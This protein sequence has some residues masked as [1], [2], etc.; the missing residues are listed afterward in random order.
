MINQPRKPLIIN[1]L[2]GWSS[3][4]CLETRELKG[5]LQQKKAELKEDFEEAKDKVSDKIN[6]I[7]DRDD[8]D[9]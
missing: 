3:I 8:K 1:G 7:L 4:I 2:R 6:D 9:R 5:K